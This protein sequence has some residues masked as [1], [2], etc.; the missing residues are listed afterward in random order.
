[1][2]NHL[3][4]NEKELLIRLR[5]GDEEAFAHLYNNY[6]QQLARN[7]IRVLKSK[8][9]AQDATQD[10]F[11]RVWDYRQAIDPD[12]PF[13][14]LLVHIAK[15]VTIDYF[16]K[17]A[18]DERLQDYILHNSRLVY[19]H[20]EEHVIAKEQIQLV[21]Q[22]IS[23]L[24]AKQRTAYTLHKL[25][26]K[27]YKEVSEIMG[28]SASTINKHIYNASQFVKKQMKENHALFIIVFISF[29]LSCI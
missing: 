13:I 1:M 4:P 20:I 28:I 21:Q 23:E 9:L 12:Q 17:A 10:L 7:F 5:D 26:G 27:S 2:V 22:I 11:L 25:E 3:V 8:E 29:L 24:P 14:A 15:R 6:K 16:R 19:T 18:K